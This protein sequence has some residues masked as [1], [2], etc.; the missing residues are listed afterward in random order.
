MIKT[1]YAK[2]KLKEWLSKNYL[3]PVFEGLHLFEEHIAD[4]GD[5]VLLENRFHVLEG[6]TRE[7][8]I[9]E[10][11]VR[12]EHNQIVKALKGYIDLLPTDWTI[13]V[14]EE[15][16]TPPQYLPQ[17]PPKRFKMR[18]IFF[19]VLGIVIIYFGFQEVRFDNSLE[20]GK[21]LMFQNKHNEAWVFLNKAVTAGRKNDNE[22]LYEA[23]IVRAKVNNILKNT[24]EAIEDANEAIRLKP[25][26]VA[27][28]TRGDIWL[29]N[30]N[31]KQAIV[32]YTEAIKLNSTDPNIWFNRG[33]ALFANRDFTSAI[34]DFTRAMEYQPIVADYILFARASAYE[35]LNKKKEALDDY[36]ASCTKGYQKSCEKLKTL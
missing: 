12:I 8:T 16:N 29:E 9:D 13:D 32:D 3:N 7:Q 18:Y 2:P 27:F 28:A 36:Q 33:R 22:K 20:E 26:P 1:Y 10:R 30:Q 4:F 24:N 31:L 5:V 6:R 14:T 34:S 25:I 35:A 23:L 15:P 21:S 11:D 19:T 17:N